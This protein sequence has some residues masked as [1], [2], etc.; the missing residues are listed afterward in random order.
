MYGFDRAADHHLW[1]HQKGPPTLW[2][3]AGRPVGY[4]YSAGSGLIGPL[5]GRDDTAAALVLHAELARRRGQEATLFIPGTARPLVASALDAGLRFNRPPGL[6]LL[7]DGCPAPTA[8][9]ISGYWL[10]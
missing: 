5:A 1:H 4:A 3:Q 2:E 6:L 8:L 10:L 9:A 7:S